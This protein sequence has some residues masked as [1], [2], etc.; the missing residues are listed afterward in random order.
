MRAQTLRTPQDEKAQR[1]SLLRNRA[2]MLST[3]SRWQ[4]TSK[5]L[6]DKILR[7]EAPLSSRLPRHSKPAGLSAAAPNLQILRLVSSLA[8]RFYQGP[9]LD[10]AMIANT[11]GRLMGELP[12]ALRGEVLLQV[13]FKSHP[14]RLAAW[15]ESG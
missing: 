4:S 8:R 10:H 11:W 6:N 2:R 9:G 14:V 3:W 12:Q 13:F 7:C 5:D 15:A 1:I